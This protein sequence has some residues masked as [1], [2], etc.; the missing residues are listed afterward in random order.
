MGPVSR[1]RS[2]DGIVAKFM[3]VVDAVTEDAPIAAPANTT[4]APVSN[5]P[6]PE[7]V[8]QKLLELIAERT[9]YPPEMLG[10]EMNLEADL[11][12]DSIKRVEI[13][14]SLRL[15]FL[16]DAG[17][18]AHE[19]MGPVSRERSVDGIVA[20]FMEVVDTVSGEAPAS[21]S[22]TI[23]EPATPAPSY[24]DGQTRR[25]V[26][27][28]S[29]VATPEAKNWVTKGA[30]Y[31]VT[32][33][34]GDVAA[35]LASLVEQAGA[36]TLMV[37]PSVL[38]ADALAAK[39]QGLGGEIAGLLHCAPLF[40]AADAGLGAKVLAEQVRRSTES[41]YVV[42]SAVGESLAARTDAVVIAASRM[43]GAFGFDDKTD[44]A[45][46]AGGP[47]GVLK[48]LAKE[49]TDAQVRAVDVS[50]AYDA[51]AIAQIIFDEAGRQDD[52]VEIGWADDARWQL[53]AEPREVPLIDGPKAQSQ[54][55]K[56]AIVLVTGGARGIT[57]RCLMWLSEKYQPRFV[58]AGSSPVPAVEEPAD[59]AAISDP[60]A[61]R[62]HLAK[63]AKANGAAISIPEIE[64][65]SRAILKAREIR[66]SLAEIEATGAKVEYHQC[67][68][69][70]ETAL[71]GFVDSLYATHGRIDGVIH[72]AGVI[73]D[74]LVV[75]KTRES[76]RRVMATK[77]ES[78]FTLAEA[79]KPETVKFCAFFTSVAGR[80][81]NRGQGDYGAAN[82]IVSKFARRL[83]QSWPGRVVALSWGPWDSDGMVSDEIKAQFTALGIEAIDP[84]LG[85]RALEAEILTTSDCVPEVVWGLGPWAND[86]ADG[87]GAKTAVKAAE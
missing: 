85:I 38:D 68:V 6:D 31:I 50:D 52:V 36:T 15:A 46:G 37:D 11:G 22:V 67:D 63:Q 83:D 45:P 57:A 32:Q 29:L 84:D 33:D 72:G 58:L 59:T 87:Q 49:W 60:M 34:A 61:L 12:I 82:E 2:V 14:A 28:P 17:E 26:M 70:D 66:E 30:T 24:T 55:D 73:E 23:M 44:F 62:A 41:L 3:E 81:G 7:S 80:F 25:F 10:R 40:D 77:A 13:L 16:A 18:A 78:A 69:R 43:G 42:L 20:K 71:T 76:Y 19:L 21:S 56:D 47:A 35:Q 8:A 54:L 65:N 27:V 39:V 86:M 5:R 79:L 48:T 75:D 53:L 9:G 74:Q 51:A 64:K 1:E 4:A